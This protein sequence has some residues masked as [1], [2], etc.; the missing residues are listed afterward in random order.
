MVNKRVERCGWY[1]RIMKG[2]ERF[3]Q[4]QEQK[5]GRWREKSTVRGTEIYN[6][7]SK[8]TLFIKLCLDGI[9]GLNLPLGFLPVL[10]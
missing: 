4:H 7:I 5:R 2:R 10:L 1:K 8:K 9:E 3:I 6:V